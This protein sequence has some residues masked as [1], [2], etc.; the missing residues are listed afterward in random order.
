MI[1]EADE[2]FVLYNVV[3]V[4]F[5]KCTENIFMMVVERKKQNSTNEIPQKRR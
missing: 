5:G 1:F 2:V 3:C 4:I